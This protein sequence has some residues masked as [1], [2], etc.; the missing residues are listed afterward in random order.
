MDQWEKFSERFL[1]SPKY[2]RYY[3]SRLCARKNTLQRF[4]DK[5]CRRI[6]D[7]YV[8]SDTWLLAD[9]FKNDSNMCL[10][11]YGLNPVHFFS[12]PGLAWQAPM[13]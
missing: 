9:V 12:V 7:L 8:Q 2:G 5:K 13:K 11:I 6:Y 4:W 1:Q 3:W 10:E